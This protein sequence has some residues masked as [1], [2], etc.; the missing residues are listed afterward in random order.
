MKSPNRNRL[1][2]DRVTRWKGRLTVL[3]A[4]TLEF[5]LC[6]KLTKDRLR[7]G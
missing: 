1:S 6:G 4:G 2:L 5:V 3:T 7:L